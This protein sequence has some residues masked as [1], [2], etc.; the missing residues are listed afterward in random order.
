MRGDYAATELFGFAAVVFFPK[1]LSATILNA[2]RLALFATK[3]SGFA[4]S[5]STN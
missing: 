1:I 4:H 2:S 3:F 5:I